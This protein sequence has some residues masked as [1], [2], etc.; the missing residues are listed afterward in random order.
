MDPHF[1]YPGYNAPRTGG[2]PYNYMGPPLYHAGIYPPRPYFPNSYPS[3]GLPMTPRYMPAMVPY[4]Y[5]P[6]AQ[7]SYMQSA[8]QYPPSQTV[9]SQ[10]Y[11]HAQAFRAPQPMV[12]IPNMFRGPPMP[13]TQL[14]PVGNP[15]PVNTQ[16]PTA[17]SATYSFPYMNHGDS[18]LCKPLITYDPQSNGYTYGDM[19][20]RGYVGSFDASGT[21]GILTKTGSG[22]EARFGKDNIYIGGNKV[23]T[24]QKLWEIINKETN[25]RAIIRTVGKTN[26][27]GPFHSLNQALIVWFGEMPTFEHILSGLV[28][29]MENNSESPEIRVKPS[30]RESD[31]CSSMTAYIWWADASQGVLRIYEEQ[32]WGTDFSGIYFKSSTLSIDGHKVKSCNALHLLVANFNKCKVT[33]HKV[34]PRTICGITVCWEATMV[35]CGPAPESLEN[36]IKVNSKFVEETLNNN[37]VNEVIKENSHDSYENSIYSDD[38]TSETDDESTS[39]KKKGD[40]LENLNVSEDNKTIL[41]HEELNE[42]LSLSDYILI[43]GCIEGFNKSGNA[44]YINY[45]TKSESMLVWFSQENFYKGGKKV[46]ANTSLSKILSV[47]V[48]VRAIIS[49]SSSPDAVKFESSKSNNAEAKYLSEARIV[50]LGE[51]PNKNIVIPRNLELKERVDHFQ[52]NKGV[53]SRSNFSDMIAYV[54]WSNSNQGIL[55]MYEEQGWGNKFTGILFSIDSIHINGCQV[56]SCQNLFKLVAHF[57]RC[58][59]KACK[60]LPMTMHGMTVT[61]EAIVVECDNPTDSIKP[62]VTKAIK[63]YK[64]QLKK[65]KRINIG[66]KSSAP[67]SSET[68]STASPIS[69]SSVE[70]STLSTLATNF[71]EVT[72][73]EPL[74]ENYKTHENTVSQ[75]IA[76]EQDTISKSETS[77]PPSQASS[78]S[79]ESW[80]DDEEVLIKGKYITG[81]IIKLL[82]DVGVAQWKSMEYGEVYISFTPEN[83]Y[84]DN[85]PLLY[86]I[87]NQ[88][89]IYT[90]R[91]NFYVIPCEPMYL[92]GMTINLQATCGWM[93]SKPSY[94]PAPGEQPLSKISLSNLKI[95]K[96]SQTKWEEVSP[97]PEKVEKDNNNDA[98]DSIQ[99]S[100]LSSV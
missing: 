98:S 1:I 40:S 81:R 64:K 100:K 80:I 54:W 33:A 28:V 7:H 60:I 77:R 23:S 43:R 6:S 68:N 78:S 88:N 67:T 59:V 3:S 74:Q 35:E 76:L 21:E 70:N 61:W 69:D 25:L 13:P 38:A 65:N 53:S 57:N 42:K 9:V 37:V 5:M 51:V 17:V 36:F 87:N 56:S 55:R 8:H 58:K 72:V 89:G 11:P 44:G 19:L 20:I 91:C 84:I 32:G 50:W 39:N 49:E 46:N 71:K 99:S 24:N 18:N 10:P 94:I 31:D 52:E 15:V 79:H 62:I 63:Q 97:E 66:D 14:V 73:N 92:E 75:S 27:V 41:N 82:K 29:E 48:N 4:P 45:H 2:V 93:G 96:I 16:L 26:A 12:P 90:R 47:G 30:Q 85:T 22:V 34:T 83:I 95:C 86:K